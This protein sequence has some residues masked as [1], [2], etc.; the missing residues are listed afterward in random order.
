MVNE[1]IYLYYRKE[2]SVTDRYYRWPSSQLDVQDKIRHLRERAQVLG[3]AATTLGEGGDTSIS[4][5]ANLYSSFAG[6][7]SLLAAQL[8]YK[9]G[10]R[11]RLVKAPKCE[12]GWQGSKHFLVKGA[13]GT[14]KLVEIDYLMR[15]WSVYISFDDESWI[16]SWDS[17]EHR[18]GNMVPIPVADRHLYGFSPTYVELY[19]DDTAQPLDDHRSP[20]T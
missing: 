3:D 17:S 1:C 7:L 8:P 4:V 10:D 18:K 14:I 16:A 15:D 13:I 6:C 11:V 12:G 19:R 5:L 9:Q 2:I 20:Y